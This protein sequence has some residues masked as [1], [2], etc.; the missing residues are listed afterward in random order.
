MQQTKLIAKADEL[1]QAENNILAIREGLQ[2]DSELFASMYG[3]L[4]A[5]TGYPISLFTEYLRM[6]PE[7]KE[8]ISFVLGSVNLQTQYLLRFHFVMQADMRECAPRD[9]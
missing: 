3:F 1:R 2:D 6:F 5:K 7:T 8:C 9:R 4:R